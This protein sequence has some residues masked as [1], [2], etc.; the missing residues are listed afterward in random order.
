MWL[1]NSPKWNPL[2]YRV[3]RN[4]RGLSGAPMTT[5]DNRRT[6]ANAAGD[7]LTLGPTDKAVRVF[8]A[9]KSCVVAKGG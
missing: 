5:E 8:K 4:V 6:E 1:L 2:D 7:S 3:W 9:T